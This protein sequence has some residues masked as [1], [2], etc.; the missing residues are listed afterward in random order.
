MNNAELKEFIEVKINAIYEMIEAKH[1]IQMVVS[2]STLTQ[3]T[4]TNGRV[5]VLENQVRGMI[6]DET[7]HILNCPRVPDI[8]KLEKA[9]SD[10][11]KEN[12]EVRMI[13]KYP[14]IAFVGLMIVVVIALISVFSGWSKLNDKLNSISRE[15][16]MIL[17]KE[18]KK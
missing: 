9:I 18:S 15:Q 5:T 10:L 1:E 6:Q 12:A 4:N 3:A 14:K 2:N 16:V 7:R 8:E 11:D 17:Q 13:K